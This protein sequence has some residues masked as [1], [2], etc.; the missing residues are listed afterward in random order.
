MKKK[1]EHRSSDQSFSIKTTL[2]LE[3]IE[4]GEKT[5]F[6]LVQR[7]AFPQEVR[8]LQLGQSVH[9]DSKL[10]RLGPYIEGDLIRVG[11]RLSRSFLN[12]DSKHPIVL[13]CKNRTT[14][15]IIQDTHKNAGHEGRQ[16]VLSD[17]RRKFWVL[18]ANAEVRR[19]IGKCLGCRRR[20]GPP[21]AQKMAE[22]P[23]DR[24][25]FRLPPF[26]TSG[27]DCFGPFYVKKGR[28]QM[29]RYGVIFTCMSVRAVHLEIVGSLSTDSFICALRRFM[30][31]RGQVRTI[32]SDQGRNFIGAK[33]ELKKELQKLLDDGSRMDYEA[34]KHGINWKLNPPGASQF[35]GAWE[36]LIRS[37]RKILDALMD[38][39]PLTDETLQTLM[40]EVEAIINN[41]PLTPVSADHRDLEP[42]TPNHILLLQGG[43]P[44]QIASCTNGDLIGRKMWKQAQYLAD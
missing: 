17:L 30:S 31:R 38:H 8:R 9:K 1:H 20:L 26:F 5:I 39:Q 19:V 4:R 32:I 3:D 33:R 12:Y 27:V 22:F 41:R 14:E 10:S 25:Q 11:G 2:T 44:G 42:L 18:K 15:L 28:G 6:R 37:I 13:P 36:R 40:C 7:T 24:L 34:L 29:K 35:G 43:P 23:D 21:E 16:H